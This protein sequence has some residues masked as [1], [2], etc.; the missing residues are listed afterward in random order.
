MAG[1]RVVTD[2][3][4]HIRTR[5]FHGGCTNVRQ[6]IKYV[7]GQ[8]RTKGVVLADALTFKAG[9]SLR[10]LEEVEI[11]ADG[12]VSRNRYSYH[13]E[14]QDDAGTFFFRYDK[15]PATVR[16]IVHEEC[17]LHVIRDEP[18]YKT[19]ETCLEEVLDFILA[20][21][22]GQCP[23]DDNQQPDTRKTG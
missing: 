23:P 17:H 9:G 20:H 1:F 10:L 5:A 8:G 21:F 3:L 6:A 14:R 22:Y 15:N 4:D 7:K 11:D 19:H 2:Y 16:P 12:H 13:Y 18:R